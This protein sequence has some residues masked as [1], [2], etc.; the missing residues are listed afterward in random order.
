MH[1][2]DERAVTQVFG[3]VDALLAVVPASAS[4]ASLC[5]DLTPHGRWVLIFL[6]HKERFVGHL[7]AFEEPVAVLSM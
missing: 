6:R 4:A 1:S 7:L 3:H 5:V 2:R